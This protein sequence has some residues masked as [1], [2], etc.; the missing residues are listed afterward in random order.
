MSRAAIC[1]ILLLTVGAAAGSRADYA[2]I[3][4]KFR[5]IEKQ[6]ARGHVPFTSAELNSY[7]QTELPK[8]APPGIRHPVVE[9]NGSN[10]ATG[11]ALIDFVRLRSAQGKAPNWLLRNLLQGE[12]EVAVTARVRSADGMATVDL[13]RVEVAGVPI[14]GGALE[15]LIDNYLRPHYPDAKIGRPFALKHGIERLEVTP[16]TA[17]AV[18]GKAQ[19][20]RA[21]QAEGRERR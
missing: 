1:S 9:L 4:Q 12:H 10:T 2:S 5:Q 3:R 8:V 13:Q 14:S 16:G 18:V 15:F 6:Q 21:A 11:R 17:W 7:V 19:P 20:V